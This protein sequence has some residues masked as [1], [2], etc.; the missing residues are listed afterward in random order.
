MIY[1][2]RDNTIEFDF[3]V[4]PGA[5]PEIIRLSFSGADRFEKDGSGNL[6]VTAG[7]HG[8]VFRKPSTRQELD[9]RKQP[10]EVQFTVDDLGH[11]YVTGST[12][13]TDFPTKRAHQGGL[14]TGSSSPDVFVT[15]MNPEGTGLIFSTYFGSKTNESP[16]AIAVDA[17]GSACITGRTNAGYAGTEGF[18]LKNALQSKTGDS[19]N[20]FVT[21]LD[22]SGV[23][24]YS[25][26]FGG[27]YEDYG[28]DIAVDASGCVAVDGAGCMYVT[29][30]AT[31]NFPVK[32]KT[33][34]MGRAGRMG[35]IHAGRN[36]RLPHSN[37]AIQPKP[38]NGFDA[39]AVSGYAL[40]W[41]FLHGP[42]NSRLI[43][44]TVDALWQRPGV[45]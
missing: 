14:Y 33:N 5:D 27:T 38:E 6:S 45:C 40:A 31:A 26:L 2:F 30:K 42:H 29:G 11:A 16:E 9:G 20:A 37:R 18:P 10:V 32:P 4:K 17:K 7:G 22:S 43:F 3:K 35:R 41:C 23:L 39:L 24:Y 12:G 8:L 15:K 28:K 34:G 19:Q 25:T 13:S 21:V 1:Y 44:S 36:I